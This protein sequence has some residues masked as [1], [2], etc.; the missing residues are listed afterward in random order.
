MDK[1]LLPR[2]YAKALYKFALEKGQTKEV[3]AMMQNLETAFDE[4][5]DLQKIMSNP[6][7]SEAEKNSLI[8]A[9]AGAKNDILDD[10]VKLLIKNNRI[11]IIRGT[12]LDYIEI[13]RQDKNIYHVEITSAAPLDVAGRDRLKD[14]VERHID[15]GATA[16]Y[17]YKVNPDLI[18]GFTVTINNR[19]LDASVSNELK[20]L[21]LS[22]I[23]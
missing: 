19:R 7:V 22:L 11:D 6:F 2:R 16:E 9:A 15:T 1:G 3:Y 14:M 20:Q 12:V 17:T 4:N 13:Y 18:G 8:N 10:F 23:K 5:P 21:R